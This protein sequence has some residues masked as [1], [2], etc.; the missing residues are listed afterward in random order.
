MA[1]LPKKT[2][3]K[4]KREQKAAQYKKARPEVR[5]KAFEL[6]HGRCVWPTCRRVLSLEFAHE[7]EVEWRGRGGDPTALDIVVTVCG[8]C[9]G[10]IHPRVGGLKKRMTGTRATGFT[11]EEKRENAWVDVTPKDDRHE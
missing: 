4:T 2:D 1:M 8:T 6:D 9:H 5:A 3:Y 11:F 7:H 10:D